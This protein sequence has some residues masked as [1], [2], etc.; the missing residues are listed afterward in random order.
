MTS[1]WNFRRLRD[2]I[3]HCDRSSRR[4]QKKSVTVK[5]YNKVV[6][7]VGMSVGGSPHL[8]ILVFVTSCHRAGAGLYSRHPGSSG[9]GVDPWSLTDRPSQTRVPGGLAGRTPIPGRAVDICGQPKSKAAETETETNRTN[10]V[11]R[12]I[13]VAGV[14]A[15]RWRRMRDLNPR[16]VISPNTISNRAP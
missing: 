9:P 8:P 4:G 6:R 13:M 1:R 11:R 10:A 7:S 2:R 16:G 3:I 12:A 14:C 5:Q 15:G